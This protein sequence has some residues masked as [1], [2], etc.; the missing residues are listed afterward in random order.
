MTH[1]YIVVGLNPCFLT[2]VPV[3]DWGLYVCAWLDRYCLFIYFYNTIAYFPFVACLYQNLYNFN[4]TFKFTVQFIEDGSKDVNFI[5]NWNCK[6]QLTI[7]LAVRIFFLNEPS[8]AFFHKFLSFQTAIQFY[9]KFMQKTSSPRFK[10]TTSQ[11]WVSSYN[12]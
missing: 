5:C 10:L 7:N 12:Y 1:N 4:I 9:N 3:V 11:S 8:Q 2:H 6:C